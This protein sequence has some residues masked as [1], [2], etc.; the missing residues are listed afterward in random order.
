[1]NDILTPNGVCYE[2]ERSPYCVEV[3]G[4]NFHFSTK[5]N[6][7]RFNEYAIVKQEWLTDSLTRRFHYIVNAH[8]LALFQLYDQQEKRGFYV[9]NLVTGAVYDSARRPHFTIQF[10]G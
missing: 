5:R 8:T 9:V 6:A 3:D 7:D 10:G 1:M 2:L 4:F